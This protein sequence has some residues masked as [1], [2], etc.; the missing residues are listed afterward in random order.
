MHLLIESSQQLHESRGC[1]YP[2]FVAEA[3][4]LERL[5]HLP[6]ITQLLSSRA[7]IGPRQSG[8][9]I[10]VFVQVSNSGRWWGCWQDLRRHLASLPDATECDEEA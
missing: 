10:C 2:C 8:F 1:H 7:E 3:E 5:I 6:I 9:S 4:G